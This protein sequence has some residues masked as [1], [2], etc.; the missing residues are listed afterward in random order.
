MYSNRPDRAAL[1]RP[2]CQW[3]S[4]LGWALFAQMSAMVA[5]QLLVSLLV[6][7][8]APSLLQSPFFLWILSTGSA[9]GVG[10]PAACL[11]LRGLPIRLPERRP[12][13]PS[14][15]GKALVT[16]LGLIYLSNLL[17]LMLTQLLGALRGQAITN[18]VDSLASYPTVLNILLGC[19]I[20]PVAEEFL[21]RRL[22]LERLRPYG[23]RFAILTSALCFGLFHG[24]LNQ[25]FYAFTVGALFAYVILR[26][27]CLWQTI[28]LHALTNASSVALV[29]L[30]EKLGPL[31][32]QLTSLLVL[33]SI[34]VGMTFLVTGWR[35]I[36]LEP[37]SLSLSEGW[38]W[39]LFFE[40]PGVI[41]FCLLALLLTASY[42]L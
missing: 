1:L 31:G 8:T 24:N 2:H 19:V 38:K 9:Y 17:T 13:A 33:G 6:R 23:D 26:T 12:M 42:F 15:F 14:G 4:R 21:F 10:I 3:F 16:A 22:L 7:L 35:D 36:R 18:P 5:V 40:N 39:R 28:L 11:V 34:V 29:P 32:D 27:G 37:G 20:A 25:F 30:L 41:A